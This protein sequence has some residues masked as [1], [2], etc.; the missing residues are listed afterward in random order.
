MS[1]QLVDYIVD[2]HHID[3]DA[4]CLKIVKEMIIASSNIAK[5]KS[6]KEK[7]FLYDIVANGRTGIDVDKLLE[8]MRVMD[9]EIKNVIIMLKIL[10]N[11]FCVCRV[12]NDF[13]TRSYHPEIVC[14]SC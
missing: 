10:E 2:E 14:N 12:T 11:Y 7:L 6:A 4:N 8:S 1:V 5:E 9:N 3:I 13:R